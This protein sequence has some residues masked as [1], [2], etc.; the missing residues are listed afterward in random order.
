MSDD[1]EN[2]LSDLAAAAEAD[3]AGG[4]FGDGSPALHR[5]VTRVRRRRVAR[6]TGTGVAVACA[7]GALAFG[8]TQ[9]RPSPGPPVQATSD[10]PAQFDRCGKY[11]GDVLADSDVLAET[12][13]VS[14]EATLNRGP[15]A[16]IRV[17][18]TMTAPA[19]IDE[20][21]VYGT[22][23]T[24]VDSAGVVVGVHEGPSVPALD[25]VAAQFSGAA[26]AT[27]PFPLRWSGDFPL[28]SCDQY[29]DGNGAVAIGFGDYKLLVAQTVGYIE[30][31]KTR[32]GRA[33]AAVPLVI[34]PGHTPYPGQPTPGPTVEP[35]SSLPSADP[36]DSAADDPFRC[37]ATLDATIHTLPDAAGLTL[38][39]DLPEDGWST[40]PPPWSVTV[41]S[42]D[43]KEHVMTGG[44]AGFLALVDS[45]GV[46]AALVV[47]D[48]APP[49][50]I[51]VGPDTTAVLDGPTLLVPCSVEPVPG[52]TY[53]AWPYI[54]ATP[55][56]GGP[57]VTVVANPREI[58]FA[59]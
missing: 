43:E 34:G 32:V 40:E 38:A 36:P 39:A 12:G 8:V 59:S 19:N 6:Q 24:V 5:V 56:E 10:W 23:L 47:P 42:S 35:S 37:G 9:V 55:A 26:Y 31:G 13:D 21:W 41:G 49:K 16:T 22:E 28:V 25:D 20:G 30:G 17:E 18:T 4:G 33:V 54:Y 50:T 44:A 29:P 46:V 14:L 51:T 45:S 53:T 7:A 15:G 11:V 3:A 27:Y 58:T 1:L 52:A 2:L 57:D 48:A